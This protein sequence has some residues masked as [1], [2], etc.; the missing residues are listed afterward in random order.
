MIMDALRARDASAEDALRAQDTL[1]DARV[2]DGS[3]CSP[4][5]AGRSADPSVRG[6]SEAVLSAELRTRASARVSRAE[7]VLLAATR[8]VL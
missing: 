4:Q 8:R 3:P 5:E 7:G 6:L 2:Q 1:A